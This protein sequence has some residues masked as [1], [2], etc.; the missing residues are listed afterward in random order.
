MYDGSARSAMTK[1]D[2]PRCGAK[3]PLA[4]GS[5]EQIA[6]S[7]ELLT[8]IAELRRAKVLASDYLRRPPLMQ[9][10]AV[11]ELL[12]RV[13]F[14]DEEAPAVCI[15]DTGVHS[16]HPLLVNAIAPGDMHAADPAWGTVDDD[17]GQ[18]GTGMAGIALYG[19]LSRVLPGHDPLV[20]HHRIE[21]AKILPPPPAMNHPEVYG[22]ITEQGVSRAII[23]APERNRVI[24]MAVTTDDR[25]R[26]VPSSW[27]AAIDQMCSG[28]ADEIPKLMFVSAGNVHDIRDPHVP[29]TYPATNFDAAG[30]EDPA[31][32]WN[33]IT[34][35]AYTEKVFIQ[36]RDFQGWSPIADVGDLCPSSRTSLAWGEESF[37]GWPI[38]PEIVVEGGNYAT[39]G[40]NRDTP[41]DLSLL[42][43]RMGRDGSLFQGTSDTSPAT[44]EASRLAAILWSHYPTLWPETI[45]ALLV[46]SAGWTGAMIKR[47]PG[48]S[49]DVIHRRMRCFGFG[50][51]ELG[52]ALYSAENAVTMV[53]EGEIQPFERDGAAC[54]TKEMHLHRLPWPVDVLESMGD[55]KVR[56]RVTLSYFIEPSPGRRGWTRSH[57]YQSHGLR[58]DVKRPLESGAAFRRRL[59][60]TAWEHPGVRPESVG[61]TRNWVVGSQG[62]TNGSIHGDWWE[63]LASELAACG[64]IAVYPVTGWWKERPHKGRIESKT[65]YSLIVS[66][67][68]PEQQVDLYAAIASVA[69]VETLVEAD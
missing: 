18:H 55:A 54:R 37:A 30:V 22:D 39:D 43:T 8:S 24:C 62:R 56:M 48:D 61:E 2:S 66:I 53:F 11:D 46:H 52:R 5:G 34:V 27:S 63:G 60:K 38:K 26:G 41:E 67:E 69:E 58:F 47:V 28:V 1:L 32:A 21:S 33:V 42:T 35:G 13:T 57:R 68:A 16:G 29:Y 50:V 4:F 6:S 10:V 36:D 20:L 45:R 12:R 44:A 59:T 15:L 23:G 19:C 7:I 3:V 17:D 65:R 25:D 9:R 51:P 14:A 64:Q 31:Q 49:R 40:V